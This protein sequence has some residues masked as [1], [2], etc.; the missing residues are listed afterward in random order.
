MVHFVAA[1]AERFRARP[2]DSTE[3]MVAFVRTRA[4]YVAQTS[5]YGYLKT[6]MGTSFRLYFEDV[7]FA[8]VIRTSSVRLF[9]DCAADLAV[10][11]VAVVCKGERDRVGGSSVPAAEAAAM[12]CACYRFVL[13]SALSEADRET[14][15]GDA[16]ERF[17]ARASAT[18]WHAAE[19][20][21]T[22]FT[23]SVDA[24]IRHAPV[25][26]MFKELDRDIVRNSIRFRWRDV[27][28]VLRK[29]MVAEAVLA[30]WRTLGPQRPADQV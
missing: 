22:A 16:I 15:V 13:E 28:E 8:E 18:D 20:R 4:S 14:L 10:F 24:V 27:R 29:R 21:E 1:F 3:A 23:A 19:R 30:D 9:L 6:R 2:I 17:D 26:D 12:A 25:I 7:T 11:A 5:L